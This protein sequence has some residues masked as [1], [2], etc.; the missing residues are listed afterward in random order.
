MTHTLHRYGRPE[1]FED[2]YIVTAMPARGFN[3]EDCVPKQKAFLEAALRH[4][5]VN[6]GNSLK[7]AAHRATKDLRPTV[8]WKRDN[9]PHP[10]A[11]IDEIDRPT[12]VSAVFDNY[13]A[14]EAFLAELAEME[15]GLSVNISG[16]ATRAEACCRAVGLTRHS[17]EFALGFQGATEKMPE[18]AS[19]RLATMCG[20]GMVSAT[21]SKKM[22]E[23]V[24]SGRRSP[25]QACAYMARFCVCGSF[26]P[27]RAERILKEAAKGE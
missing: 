22:V 6:I 5:P 21:L 3:D 20:H 13:E 18:D 11:V 7:G 14:V 8:H 10:E 27:A 9:A 26:N 23:W 12:S 19:R 25:E 4:G 2:D 24:R 15:L 17:V 1:D 16:V